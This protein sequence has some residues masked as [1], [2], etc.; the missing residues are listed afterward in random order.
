M[1]HGKPLYGSLWHTVLTLTLFPAAC[2]PPSHR[3]RPAN[4]M[5]W[6]SAQFDKIRFHFL[7]RVE[8][9]SMGFILIKINKILLYQY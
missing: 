4:Q 3:A 5:E 2:F 8:C 6:V 7:T 9:A 1:G